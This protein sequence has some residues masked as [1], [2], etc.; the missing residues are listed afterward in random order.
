MANLEAYLEAE[1]RGILPQE[2]VMLL[3][4]ARNRG[5]ISSP[6]Q[7]NPYLRGAERG[8]RTSAIGAASM[9][10]VFAL[11]GQ[12][13][14]AGAEE[15]GYPE[16]AQGIRQ[17]AG[18]P[19]SQSTKAVI[20]Q[21][22]QNKLQ[23]Q[24][25]A[26]RIVDTGGEFAAGGGALS[27]VV[28]KVPSLASNP[29][30][31]FKL[32]DFIASGAAGAGYQ[33]V[34]ELGGNEAMKLA[35]SLV[36]PMAV[37]SAPAITGATKETLTN[38]GNVLNKNK[39]PQRAG[40]ELYDTLDSKMLTGNL[41]IAAQQLPEETLRRGQEALA[42]TPEAEQLALQKLQ[43]SEAQRRGA[44][45][46]K[47]VM[48]EAEATKKTAENIKD[49]L[50][51]A[52]K[53]VTKPIYKEAF[54]TAD[55]FDVPENYYQT[56]ITG[57]DDFTG[58][59][60]E[61]KFKNPAISKL[62]SSDAFREAKASVLDRAQ[63]EDMRRGYYDPENDIMSSQMLN[64]I[65][66][67]LRGYASSAERSIAE[68]GAKD[69]RSYTRAANQ[70]INVLKSGMPEAKFAQREKAS[71]LYQQ[72]SKKIENIFGAND[73]GLVGNLLKFDELD[74]QS[75]EK[76]VNQM[77]ALFQKE[78]QKILDVK[79]TFKEFGQEGQFN[80]A[81]GAYLQYAADKLPAN[82]TLYDYFA[83][84]KQQARQFYLSL[85]K[86]QQKNAQEVI[87]MGHNLNIMRNKAFDQKVGAGEAIRV[88][89]QL[90]AP[91][92]GGFMQTMGNLFNKYSGKNAID[93]EIINILYDPNRSKEFL[94]NVGKYKT[95]AE[96]QN[97]LVKY[98]LNYGQDLGT[99]M[100]RVGIQT[101][102]RSGPSQN[103]Q[104]GN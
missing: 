10:D 1:R 73:K 55:K 34:G 61:G 90:V 21:A 16:T 20:D 58:L 3:Q 80:K 84:N 85:P 75:T 52:R 32:K 25:A 9:G 97:Y 15:L 43:Q 59:P 38:M 31:Q 94:S 35:A 91:Q 56:K 95:A 48:G 71:G 83:K 29:L 49:S 5:L 2:K 74:A 39:I 70:T 79:N 62:E 12:I 57:K 19:L 66:S 77:N 68:T 24:N 88:A 14:A 13:A 101:L 60:I 53:T 67:E 96:K 6:E 44:I 17:Y 7:M 98:L 47:G 30:A 93:K 89:G 11:P 100:D 54:E 27:K 51:E 99:T 8:L 40:Q 28:S 23:P 87:R 104:N 69:A 4:E 50:E 86:G 37:L 82:K 103:N 72:F 76:V 64:D 45:P 22:T 92:A 81:F 33:G 65:H 42:R 36:T 63:P 18:T 102:M 78:P 41:P 26:E 46:I